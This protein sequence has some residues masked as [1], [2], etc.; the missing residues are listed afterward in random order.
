MSC[1][2]SELVA[3]WEVTVFLNLF[4]TFFLILKQINNWVSTENLILLKCEFTLLLFSGIINL[5][6]KCKIHINSNQF[7]QKIDK[8]AQWLYFQFILNSPH[9]ITEESPSSPGRGSRDP[10]L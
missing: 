8:K 2:R 3:D 6:N 7:Q 10:V 9:R 4:L 5:K 1:V